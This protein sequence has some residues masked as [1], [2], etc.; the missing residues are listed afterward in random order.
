MARSE[1]IRERV[2]DSYGAAVR[3]GRGCCG[4]AVPAGVAAKT[5]GYSREELDALPAAAVVSSFGCGNPLAFV[6]VG[7]GQT[8]LDLGS[9]G[10]IDLLLAADRVGPTGRVIG[11]DMTAEMIERARATARDA[12]YSNV[13]VREGLIEA[14]PVEDASV[15]WVISNCVINLSP[16]KE[17]VFAEIARVLR[18][19]GGV[20]IS[21]IVV[22]RM[23][24]WLRRSGRLHCA[25]VAGAISE[26]A[27]LD[28]L[29]S[30]GL[31]AVAVTERLVYGGAQ[32][33]ELAASE[34]STVRAPRW[35]R[36]IAG[37]AVGR[38]AA[39]FEGRVWSAKFTA[40]RPAA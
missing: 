2:R 22:E 1:A 38:L 13:E 16:E 21:D 17:R 30:A 3:Q 35:V 26:S 33:R 27:Y 5:A 28:G 15:D 9:G 8:V 4:D 25:C 18:P 29:R 24:W 14:L 20:S 39:G 32:L 7:E 10:G 6:E 12:G 36:R 40:R 34:A 23:P 19:G 37:G 31:E 11:V